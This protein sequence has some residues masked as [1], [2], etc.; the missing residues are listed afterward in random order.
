[1]SNQRYSPV[2]LLTAPHNVDDFDCGSQRETLW[3]R[4]HGLSSQGSGTSRVYVVRRQSDDQVVGFHALATG[5]ALPLETPGRVMKGVGGYP[6]S[7]IVLTR[8]GVDL[9]EQGQGLGRSMLVDALQR[10]HAAADIVGVRALLIHT[11]NEQA[12]GF[13]LGLAEFKAS[14]TDPL[15][16]FVLIKDLRRLLS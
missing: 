4:R 6:I 12:R 16:L 9:S 8:L 7:V 14:P 1:V 15:H 2:D 13:F 11:A 10:V 3:L 5:A